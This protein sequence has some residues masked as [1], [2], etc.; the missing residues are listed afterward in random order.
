MKKLLSLLLITVM[1]FS[2]AGCS[3]NGT[4]ADENQTW[5][6]KVHIEGSEGLRQSQGWLK[7]ADMITEKTDGRE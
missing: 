3:G 7:W 6:L 2:F 1:I 4:A 5:E